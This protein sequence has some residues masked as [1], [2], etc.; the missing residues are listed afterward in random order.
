MID[1]ARPLPRGLPSLKRYSPIMVE[2]PA[3][4]T[5]LDA[6]LRQTGHVAARPDLFDERPSTL[7]TGHLTIA[8]YAPPEPGWP[9]VQL[10]QWP[11]DF[12]ANLPAH[13]LFARGAYTFEL[14]LDPLRLERAARR[15]LRSLEQR[16]AVNLEVVFPD[17]SAPPNS[18]SH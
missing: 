13:R 8:H 10:C 3:E 6:F 1:T 5:E 17:W 15:L 16:H 11:A 18:S 2:T 7:P 12:A 9:F 14:F 4:Q